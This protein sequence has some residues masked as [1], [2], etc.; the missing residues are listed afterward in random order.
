MQTEAVIKI[1]NLYKAFGTNQVLK[2]FSLDVNKGESLV[3]LGKSGSGKSVLI[4]CIIGLM[5]PDQGSIEV[6]GRSEE[7]RV[8][9]ECRL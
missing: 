8:G 6:F 7:R 5:R 4:K 1:K 2:D 3:V 9:K